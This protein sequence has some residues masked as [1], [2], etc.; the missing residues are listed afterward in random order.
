MKTETIQFLLWLL[1]M[2]GG[3]A[4][5]ACFWPMVIKLMELKSKKK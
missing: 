1:S 5:V 2:T 4:L 3:L